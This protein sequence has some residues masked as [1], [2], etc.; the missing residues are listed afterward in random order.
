LRLEVTKVK[1]VQRRAASN[2]EPDDQG[3]KSDKRT[4]R[5]EA[6]DEEMER[7]NGGK[8]KEDPN[9]DSAEVG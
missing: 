9:A 7:E 4:E 3:V 2:I 5:L 6:D 8:G 1:C